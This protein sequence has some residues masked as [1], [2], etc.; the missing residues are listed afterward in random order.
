MEAINAI[1]NGVCIKA[2]Q[3]PLVAEPE[4]GITIGLSV[5]LLIDS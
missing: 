4:D 2:I 3:S 1:V 5:P